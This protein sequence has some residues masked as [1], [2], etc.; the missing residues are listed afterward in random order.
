MKAE[1]LHRRCL[2]LSWA[3]NQSKSQTIVKHIE[4]KL[5]PHFEGVWN[6]EVENR[7]CDISHHPRCVFSSSKCSL[8]L[9]CSCLS[10]FI[11]CLL[12]HKRAE[13]KYTTNHEKYKI[14]GI[15]LQCDLPHGTVKAIL[16]VV[17]NGDGGD[18]DIA[19]LCWLNRPTSGIWL[20]MWIVRSYKV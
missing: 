16:Q 5:A 18:D 13:V 8:F 12:K 2:R 11:H 4:P 17:D 7:I 10:L 3:S 20:T 14:T 19:C 9:S 15:S 6:A 1:L